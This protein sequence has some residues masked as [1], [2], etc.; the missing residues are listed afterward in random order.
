MRPATRPSLWTALL[1][2]VFLLVGC[3]PERTPTPAPVFVPPTAAPTATPTPTPPPPITA[4]P[5]PAAVAGRTTEGTP[6]INDLRFL[7]DETIPD[8]T[9][10]QPGQALAKAWRVKNTGTCPW[11]AGYTLQFLR[12][13]PMGATSPQPLVPTRPGAEAVIRIDF[14]APETPGIHTSVWQAV[15]P[16]GQA[17]GDPI[18][19]LVEVVLPTA[20]P[21]PTPATP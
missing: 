2:L 7:A 13:E 14:V 3:R 6:C 20:T 9:Q 16:Q 11:G 15:S 21:S 19:I 1:V 10:V 5:G 4:S 18:Y 17:F 8:G 12:G